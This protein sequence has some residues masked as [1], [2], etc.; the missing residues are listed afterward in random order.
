[1]PF[2]YAPWTNI[3][4]SPVG[5]MSPCCKFQTTEYSKTYNIQTDNF[6]NY[7]NSFFLK[8]VKNEFA[9]KSG[10]DRKTLADHKEYF[11]SLKQNIANGVRIIASPNSSTEAR[12]SAQKMIEHNQKEMI[13]YSYILVLA[14]LF[15]QLISHLYHLFEPNL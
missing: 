15:E 8:Q 7:V 6:D 2:C 13:S 9:G 14:V 10:F 12:L 11:D 3:D 1:M 5:V 4:L